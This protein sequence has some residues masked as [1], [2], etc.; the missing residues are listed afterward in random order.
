MSYFTR[1]QKSGGNPNH[2]ELGRF[3]SASM[4][5]VSGKKGSND[6]GVFKDDATGEHH[7]V[8]FYANPEQGKTEAL[9]SALFEEM[10]AK[11]PSPKMMQ[12]NGKPA[13][14]TKWNTNYETLRPSDFRKLTSDQ[15]LQVARMYHAATLTKNWD[16]LGLTHDNVVRD[17][18]SGDMVEV[19]TG[20]SFKFRAQGGPKDYGPDIAE[21]KSLRNPS[22]ASGDVFNH[23]FAKNPALEHASLDKIRGLDMTKVQDMF[24][25]SGL[26]DQADLFKN[27]AARRT[28]LLAHYT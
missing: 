7:Y 3:A 14:V 13:V 24:A 22:N 17:K 6:G 27:F 23:I 25:K 15:Q 1:I 21:Q 5:K 9:A 4:T 28:A 2:D 26:K 10:G 19:D 16:V 12:V 11:T 20:G 8:K 18:T